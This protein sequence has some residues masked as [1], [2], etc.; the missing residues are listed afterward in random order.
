MITH[1]SNY[2]TELMSELY[3]INELNKGTFPLS[4][5]LIDCYQ[6]EDPRLQENTCATYQ[7]GYFCGNCNTI[8]LVTYKDRV[9]M[10]QQF[11]RYLK[12][13]YHD[14]ILHPGLGRMEAMIFQTFYWPGIRGSVQREVKKF[15]TCQQTKQSTKNTVNSPLS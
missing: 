10:P 6:Q 13:R 1:K 15:D 12:R 4:F 8:E 14:Y 11:Q 9:V 3:D 5:Q 7:K 2:T